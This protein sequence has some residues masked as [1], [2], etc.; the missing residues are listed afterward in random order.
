MC[1]GLPQPEMESKFMAFGQSNYRYA[2]Y[3]N[4]SKVQN[5]IFS[6]CRNQLIKS[7]KLFTFALGFA[8]SL[9]NKG[10]LRWTLSSC[11]LVW[12]DSVQD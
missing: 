1:L 8:Q 7:L 11:S 10:A 6:R 9:G 5:L 2:N 4:D 12:V 3:F